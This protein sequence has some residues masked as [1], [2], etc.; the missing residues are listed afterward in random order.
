MSDP[1]QGSTRVSRTR[2]VRAFPAALGVVVGCLVLLGL[3]GAGVRA[4]FGPQ[5]RVDAAVSETLYAGDD[6]ATGMDVLLVGGAPQR[7]QD[8]AATF[9]RMRDVR[10]SRLVVMA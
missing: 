7:V 4:D 6:R 1:S 8:L 3:L 2:S 10:R 5:L 9:E